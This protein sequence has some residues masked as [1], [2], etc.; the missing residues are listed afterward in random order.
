MIA[1]QDVSLSSSLANSPANSPAPLQSEDE[2]VEQ[3]HKI[4]YVTWCRDID[5]VRQQTGLGFLCR[6]MTSQEVDKE[7]AR[8]EEERKIDVYNA[9]SGE[10][11]Q[12]EVLSSDN[13]KLQDIDR[14]SLHNTMLQ[15]KSFS[16]VRNKIRKSSKFTS[17]P[18]K[19]RAE[20][21]DNLQF[22]FRSDPLTSM[23]NDDMTI[24]K[25]KFQHNV[26]DFDV[27]EKSRGKRVNCTD[28]GTLWDF[29]KLR[30]IERFMREHD[31][32]TRDVIIVHEKIAK[33]M[34]QDSLFT[35]RR[36]WKLHYLECSLWRSYSECKIQSTRSGTKTILY[37]QGLNGANRKEGED[38]RQTESAPQIG[39]ASEGDI[40][41]DK[42]QDK[43]AEKEID[44]YMLPEH[45]DRT[46]N[47]DKF[48]DTNKNM[49][50]GT[51]TDNDMNKDKDTDSD[52]N[53]DTDSDA[54]KE[55]INNVVVKVENENNDNDK[56]L[57]KDM[58]FLPLDGMMLFY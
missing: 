37:S 41:I 11:K 14:H 4:N 24:Q 40:T 53:K 38:E 31:C 56:D 1:F 47:I 12:D 5:E 13:A 43:G 42:A 29:R 27:G 54:N 55:T 28:D 46:A 49:N 57:P 17:L 6:L 36:K 20:F 21:V 7:H 25:L 33:M 16:K 8:E 18:V 23:E 19:D 26:R 52:V 2:R 10:V 35:R 45:T 9:L 50:I 48:Q 58:G 51:D 44:V 32:I 3:L 34:Q 39:M 22:K 30:E 15:H